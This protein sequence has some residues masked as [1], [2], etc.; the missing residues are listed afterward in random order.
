MGLPANPHCSCPDDAA[1]DRE[2]LPLAPAHSPALCQTSH[3]P[4]APHPGL[5]PGPSFPLGSQCTTPGRAPC[6]TRTFDPPGPLR[7]WQGS[8][9]NTAYRLAS[10]TGFRPRAASLGSLVRQRYF[11]SRDLRELSDDSPKRRHFGESGNDLR[12]DCFT[13]TGVGEAAGAVSPLFSTR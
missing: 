11:G 10:A 13:A 4:D 1:P 6:T 3:G 8:D 7:P 12:A 2:G 9:G 5:P